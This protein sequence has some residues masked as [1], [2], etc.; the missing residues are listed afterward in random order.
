[1]DSAYVSAIAALTGSVIG[2]LTS[3]L[4]TSQSQRS[5]L[6]A[7]LRQHDLDRREQL[8][9]DFIEEAS[10]LYADAYE[11]DTAKV[12]TLVKLYA[13]VS[14]MRVRASQAVI[15][16]ADKVVRRIIE[17]YLGPIVTLQDI[18]KALVH[19]ALDPLRDFSDA[20][21]EELQ[22]IL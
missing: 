18:E 4:T 14:R 13:L 19:D 7:Q 5:Q 2:G 15:H 8:Y 6:N 17:T 3:L 16:N 22:A 1:M 21:R 9:K 10:R 20:C 11:H 12:A